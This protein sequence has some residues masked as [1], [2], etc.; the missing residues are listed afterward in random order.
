M[1][2][3]EV[4]VRPVVF[5]NIRPTQPR[6]LPP[7]TDPEQGFF[8]IRGNGAQQVGESYS[9]SYSQSSKSS[10]ETKRRSDV[11]R[12]YQKDD[13]GTVNRDNFVDIKVATKIWKK[14]PRGLSSVGGPSTTGS[15]ANRGGIGPEKFFDTN[16]RPKEKDNIESKKTDVIDENESVA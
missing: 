12:V 7:I 6:S 5:P 3:F 15:G 1:A 10:T 8:E 9:Y 4:V 11:A 13:D 2:G 14:G 16:Q